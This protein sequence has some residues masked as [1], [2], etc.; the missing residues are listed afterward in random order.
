MTSLLVTAE[1]LEGE[2]EERDTVQV[3]LS[4]HLLTQLVE[5]R[6]EKI[7]RAELVLV[8][9]GAVLRPWSPRTLQP[10]QL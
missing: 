5:V 4:T 3:E 10:L 7:K 8:E 6:E 2:E 9:E 1:S